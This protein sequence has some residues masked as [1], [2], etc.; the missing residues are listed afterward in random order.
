MG[1]LTV[2]QS[3]EEGRKGREKKSWSAPPR[4]TDRAAGRR[5]EARE[6]GERVAPATATAAAAAGQK[7]TDANINNSPRPNARA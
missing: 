5:M 2:T 3:R 7:K 6:G 1:K 4:V